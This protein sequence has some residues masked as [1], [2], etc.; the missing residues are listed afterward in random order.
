MPLYILSLD[1]SSALGSVALARY[2]N[3]TFDIWTAEHEGAAEHSQQLLPMIQNVLDQAGIKANELTAVAFGQGPGGFTGLRVACG[4]AQGLGYALDIPL[5]PVVSNAA[6]AATLPAE[7]PNLR[8]VVLDARMNE[9]YAAVYW[10]L[11]SGDVVSLDGPVLLSSADVS[12]W[13]H[14]QMAVW[15]HRITEL[16]GPL[17]DHAFASW[18]IAGDLPGFGSDNGAPLRRGWPSFLPETVLGGAELQGY[19]WAQ[20]VRPH[21]KSVAQLAFHAWQRGATVASAEALPLY[22]RDKVAFTIAER[23]SGEVGGNPRAGDWQP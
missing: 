16:G 17:A 18:I 4:V 22:V 21:A 11:P 10:R 15:H 7:A 8:I 6:V 23:A 1:T 20:A 3:S 19:W 9:V 5:I 14:T 12:I 13:V 2:A